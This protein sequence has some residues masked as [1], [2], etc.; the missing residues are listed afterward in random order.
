LFEIVFIIII[1]YDYVIDE[2]ELLIGYGTRSNVFK[3]IDTKSKAKEKKALKVVAL[4][5]IGNISE[6]STNEN[7]EEL[8]IG[9]ELGRSCKFLVSYEKIFIIGDFR[10][11]VM[12]Y[13]EKGDLE[14][15]YIKK[16]NKLTEEV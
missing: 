16:R 3:V 1:N 9:L 2:L 13:F 7:S 5:G 11:I 8:K 6:N 14:N 12:E 4:M 10:C 15:Y